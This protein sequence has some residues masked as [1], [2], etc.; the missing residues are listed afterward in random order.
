MPGDGLLAA[1]S[2][3]SLLGRGGEVG[4][5]E[6]EGVDKGAGGSEW[7]APGCPMVQL[8]P[9]VVKPPLVVRLRVALPPMA[10][11]DINFV[12]EAAKNSELV[13]DNIFA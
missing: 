6:E 2:S 9:M 7:E 12:T 13:L 3:Q 5:E 11:T 4:E 10:Q 8:N 1:C